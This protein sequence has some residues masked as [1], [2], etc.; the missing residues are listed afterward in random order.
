MNVF[1]GR[2]FQGSGCQ[3]HQG[4]SQLFHVQIDP[5]PPA[6]AGCVVVTTP[7]PAASASRVATIS[8]LMV[9]SFQG[10]SLKDQ[11]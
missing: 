9:V 7:D 2:F 3:R 6:A 5:P 4:F 10:S 8:V 11:E 1:M